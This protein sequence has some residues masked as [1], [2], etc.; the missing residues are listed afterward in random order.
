MVLRAWGE[1]TDGDLGMAATDLLADARNAVRVLW[2]PDR[3]FAALALR[4]RV[5]VAMALYLTAT[6][7]AAGSTLPRTDFG[8]GLEATAAQGGGAGAAVEPTDYEREQAREK[9]RKIG[10]LTTWGA[11]LAKPTLGAAAVAVALFVAFW[12]AGAPVAFGATLSVV[13]HAA[14]PLALRALLGIPAALA[15]GL[16]AGDPGALLPS[17]AAALVPAAAAPVHAAL[18]ALDVFTVWTVVLTALG[19]ARL[20]GASR[21]RSLVATALPWAG[22]VALTLALSAATAA[23]PVH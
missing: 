10:A 20:S 9:A 2:A 13:V 17:S 22:L 8:D 14:L 4:P 6:L 23:P 16:T 7:L 21:T 12:V 19:M 11:A 15:H 3:T 1:G 18:S 5:A